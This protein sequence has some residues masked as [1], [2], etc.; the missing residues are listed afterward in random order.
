MFWLSPLL[1]LGVFLGYTLLSR[2]M[3]VLFLLLILVIGYLRE[4]FWLTRP[5]IMISYYDFYFLQ[6]IFLTSLFLFFLLDRVLCFWFPAIRGPWFRLLTCLSIALGMVIP[7]WEPTLDTMERALVLHDLVHPIATVPLMA[8][9][10]YWCLCQLWPPHTQPWHHLVSIIYQRAVLM[11]I[12][13]PSLHERALLIFLRIVYFSVVWTV[14]N[15]KKKEALQAILLP[16]YARILEQSLAAVI[17]ENGQKLTES[18]SEKA[19]TA[20]QICLRA[21]SLFTYHRYLLHSSQSVDDEESS[22]KCLFFFNTVLTY[23]KEAD[24]GQGWQLWARARLADKRLFPALY[25]ARIDNLA[26]LVCLTSFFRLEDDVNSDRF[27][28]LTTRLLPKSPKALIIDKNPYTRD[29]VLHR[30]CWAQFHFQ[31]TDDRTSMG[32]ILAPLSYFHRTVIGAQ[33]QMLLKSSAQY[34]RVDARKEQESARSTSAEQEQNTAE[35]KQNTAEQENGCLLTG[36][37]DQ[38]G[39]LEA[40]HGHRFLFDP[41]E[42]ES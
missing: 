42:R 21:R 28:S 16:E 12:R 13:W 35:Q 7:F 41:E 23:L 3:T 10:A 26:G 9:I 30:V 29:D 38:F 15:A 2:K 25:R 14:Y 32:Q 31:V 40:L 20:R 37:I 11:L 36:I 18:A 22:N 39:A 4:T 1:M 34:V 24:L 5:G 27:Y 19:K 8:L 17:H 33:I 6:T